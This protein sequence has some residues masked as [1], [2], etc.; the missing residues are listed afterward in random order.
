MS[1]TLYMLQSELDAAKRKNKELE[2]FYK[3]KPRY[4]EIL[5]ER[6][7]FRDKNLELLNQAIVFDNLA[8]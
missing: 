6:D 2:E 4:E 8:S 7:E 1:S 5:R 3:L